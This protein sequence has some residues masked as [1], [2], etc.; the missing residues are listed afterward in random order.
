MHFNGKLADNEE[1]LSLDLLTPVPSATSIVAT[2]TAGGPGFSPTAAQDEFVFVVE[3]DGAFPVDLLR[4]EQCWPAAQRD[5]RAIFMSMQPA[6][7]SSYRQ[8]I[9]ATRNPK[10]PSLRRWRNKR[11]KVI[12]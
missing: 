1:R 4:Q 5:A 12:I 8:V 11:W 7:G 9:L 6:T 3:G 2:L 10:A